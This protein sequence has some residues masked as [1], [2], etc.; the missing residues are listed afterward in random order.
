VTGDKTVIRGS[1]SF[2]MVSIGSV[3]DSYEKISS[4][5]SVSAWAGIL[6]YLSGPLIAT[7]IRCTTG[8]VIRTTIANIITTII[9]TGTG[10]R[11][12]TVIGITT[13]MIKPRSH[14]DGG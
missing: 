7:L 11:V 13:M 5:N 14:Y 6:V 4:T 1:R 8:A 12:T 10:T 3:V 9:P 2:N